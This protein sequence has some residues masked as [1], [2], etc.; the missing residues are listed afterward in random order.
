MFGGGMW[1][2]RLKLRTNSASKGSSGLSDTP[3]S[4]S[5]VGFATN[6]AQQGQSKVMQGA[7]LP[8]MAMG[9]KAGSRR[10]GQACSSGLSSSARQCG[11]QEGQEVVRP[12]VALT[13]VSLY[14]QSDSC[15][16]P[17][18]VYF[19]GSGD[20]NDYSEA[21]SGICGWRKTL[22]LIHRRN[23]LHVGCSFYLPPPAS[24]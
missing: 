4:N 10:M 5:S 12:G 7:V 15:V 19:L 22:F 8:G 1:D 14:V 9:H 23:F 17:R 18:G 6:H 20:L 13:G 16:V 3:F 24:P 11:L 21:Q 2:K